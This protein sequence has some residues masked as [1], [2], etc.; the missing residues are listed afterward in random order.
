M[1]RGD[2]CETKKLYT[3][4]LNDNRIF[5]LSRNKQPSLEGTTVSDCFQGK[6]GFSRGIT[7]GE[8][9]VTT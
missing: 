1:I 5:S 8:K 9:S 4:F 2:I 7:L 6:S 3:Q